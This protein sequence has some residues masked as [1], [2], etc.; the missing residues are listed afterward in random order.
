MKIDDY[1][2]LELVMITIG[3]S[4]GIMYVATDM[5]VILRKNL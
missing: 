4:I 1:V 2:N 5:N 3:I